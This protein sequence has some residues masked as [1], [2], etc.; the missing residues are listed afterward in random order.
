MVPLVVLA[1]AEMV[2]GE[3]T[4]VPFFGDVWVIVTVPAKA[5]GLPRVRTT[6]RRARKVNSRADVDPAARQSGN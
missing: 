5:G 3:E 6:N 2:T 4:V 1:V